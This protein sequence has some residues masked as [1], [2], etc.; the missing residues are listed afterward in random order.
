MIILGSSK[1]T[2]KKNIQSQVA[3]LSEQF[4][5]YSQQN[6]NNTC[7]VIHYYYYVI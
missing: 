6:S 7:V 5:R 2:Q 4:E 3:S 1:S